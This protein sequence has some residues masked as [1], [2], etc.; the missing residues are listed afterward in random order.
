MKAIYTPSPGRSSVAFQR[1][2]WV[3]LAVLLTLAI[4]GSLHRLMAAGV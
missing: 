4:N 3:L 2:V 1:L